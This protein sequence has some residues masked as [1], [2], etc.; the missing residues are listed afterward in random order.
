[1]ALVMD[2][3]NIVGGLAG[4]GHVATPLRM[5]N[6]GRAFMIAGL[7]ADGLGMLLIP[8]GIVAQIMDLPEGMAPGERS[9]QIMEILGQAML[10]VGIMA[11]GALAQRARQQHIEAGGRPTVPEPPTRRGT[12]EAETPSSE[13]VPPPEVPETRPPETG[14]PGQRLAPEPAQ[15]GAR[16]GDADARPL[17]EAISH[18]GLSTIKLT[19]QGRLVV[20]SSPCTFF[21]QVFPR[22][23]AVN[24]E[25][26]LE[27]DNIVRLLERQMSR[28]PH[29][30]DQ[31]VLYSVFERALRLQERL[32]DAQRVYR[33]TVDPSRTTL[34]GHLDT[35]NNIQAALAHIVPGD[36]QLSQSRIHH[37]EV[38]N[39]IARI[40]SQ[41][42]RIA[43]FDDWLG[44]ASGPAE[45]VATTHSRDQNPAE[46]R[47]TREAAGDLHR[48]LGELYEARRLA[49]Q[50]AGN[51]EIIIRIGQDG[52]VRD[53]VTGA[54]RPSFDISVERRGPGGAT[55]VERRLEVE[56]AGEV[57]GVTDLHT[58]I[59]HGAQKIDADVAAGRAPL[60]SEALEPTIQIHWPPQGRVR[61]IKYERNGEY[62]VYDQSD[63][64]LVRQE[65]SLIV[66]LI[67]GRGG[68][69]SP[70]FD[71]RVQRL[72]MINIIDQ[73][74][75]LI[76]RLRNSAPG[77]RTW[78]VDYIIPTERT[79]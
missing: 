58:G 57:R 78:V 62:R 42:G 50:Y 48:L 25:L 22:E 7:G 20:C 71:A 61:N 6:V 70:G 35:L 23:L 32:Q 2:I 38:I 73:N 45:R 11:G 3:V 26:R 9:A 72:S 47:G 64:V 40:Q 34:P 54:A 24:R 8:V 67:Y 30:R 76:W 60:P 69:N 41:E 68:V 14:A 43:G 79:P 46:I 75:T 44:R 16:A 52:T 1:M 36:P 74:G 15:T 21:E 12:P 27:H 37:A 33:M 39:D 77:R 31:N 66:A 5:V 49:R 29:N 53:P 28:A 56:Y 19:E 59:V 13:R 63:P 18:D 10:N 65:G 55:V 4:L 51:S 17:F